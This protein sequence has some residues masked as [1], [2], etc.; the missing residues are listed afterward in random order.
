MIAD[1]DYN[2]RALVGR[3]V[4]EAGYRATFATTGYEAL[5]SARLSPPVA[6]LADI[7]L[8]QLDGL[9]LCRLIKGDP[10]TASIVTVVF[11]VLPSEE[12][13]KK[14]GADAFISKPLEKLRIL[15]TLE[16]VTAKRGLG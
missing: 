16:E 9:A 12:R 2:V 13:A 8:P 5:D 4:T 11:S 15:K 3:F 1:A 6:I 7:L 14:A 10:G